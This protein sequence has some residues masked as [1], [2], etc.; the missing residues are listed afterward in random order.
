MSR[1]DF[2]KCIDGD[3]IDLNITDEQ[4]RSLVELGLI[5]L[6]NDL[7]DICIDEF[8]DEKIVGVDSLT[9]ARLLIENDFHPS[10]NEAVN[11]LLSQVNKATEY[12]TG[13]FFYF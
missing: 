4:Y 7:F 6:M 3:V 1:L 9:Q 5:R 13:L 8:E 2:D 12:E 11:L 10:E